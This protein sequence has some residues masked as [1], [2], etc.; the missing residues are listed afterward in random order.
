MLNLLNSI[1]KTILEKKRSLLIHVEGTRSLTCRQPVTNLST[2]FIDLA[3]ELN[4]PIIPVKF[5][6]GLPIKPLEKRLDF[7]LHYTYQNYHLG[8]AIYPE[9]IKYIGNLE[10]KNLILKRLNNL[11]NE[12]DKN[13]PNQPDFN[14]EKEIQ[15][16]MKKT[17]VSEIHAVFYK[18][19]KEIHNPTNEVVRKI[20]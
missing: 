8:K 5:T 12:K 18:V 14:F 16:W 1:K 20:C 3:L 9:D 19:L 2:I 6:G 10:R 7:P 11:G 15:S 17:E 4:L 13:F